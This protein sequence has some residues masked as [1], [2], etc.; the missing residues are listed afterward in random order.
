MRTEVTEMADLHALLDSYISAGTAPGAVAV[1]ARGHDVETAAVGTVDVDGT[2]AM[3]LDSIF[4]VAS[5]TKPITAAA[6]MVLVDDGRIGLDDPVARWLPELAS[7]VVVRTPSSE[8]DDVVPVARPEGQG[9]GFG[10]SVD[11]DTRDPWTVPGRYG[12]VGGS[13]TSAHVCPS[14][15]TVAVLLTQRE[16]TGPTPTDLMRA[17]WRYAAG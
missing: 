4:R 17:F 10:G 6:A 7:P 15:G 3:A 2:A 11:V 8:L 1:V 9:W 16:M 14:T 5:I 13:G 12:W